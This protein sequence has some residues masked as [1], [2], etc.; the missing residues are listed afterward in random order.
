MMLRQITNCVIFITDKS[1][2]F[3]RMH[4]INLLL[5]LFSVTIFHVIN[6]RI[7][8]KKI[9]I[10]D[11]SWMNLKDVTFRSSREEMLF[12]KALLILVTSKQR[13]VFAQMH[14]MMKSKSKMVFRTSIVLDLWVNTIKIHSA[15][16][17][18]SLQNKIR[19]LTISVNSVCYAPRIN[20][21]GFQFK[22]NNISHP[23]QWF[24][25]NFVTQKKT[26]LLSDIILQ[27]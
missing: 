27:E 16:E 9:S 12:Q 18:F 24:S 4:L 3:I 21:I 20:M 1:K 5:I 17:A 19:I 14:L 8:W 22:F 23:N 13:F 7:L 15:M 11:K 26:W 2:K 10:K 6:L 25:T